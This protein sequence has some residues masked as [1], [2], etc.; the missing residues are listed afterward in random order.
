MKHF[1]SMR[2]VL[3]ILCSCVLSILCARVAL[4]QVEVTTVGGEIYTGRIVD[5]NTS[6]IML[7][8]LDS[9]TVTVPKSSVQLVRYGVDNSPARLKDDSFWS[10]G[11]A[12]GTPGLVNVIGGYNFDGWGLRVSGGLTPNTAAGLQFDLRRSVGYSG[13][14]SHNIHVSIGSFAMATDSPF[15]S[16]D[17]WDYVGIGYDLNWG[18]FYLSGDLS[19]GDGTY[20][21]PQILA[22]IGYVHE[23]R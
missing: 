21:S 3:H 4:A 13:S 5:E 23:F 6:L 9:V 16:Y 22:Q 1:N 11:G 14:L 19:F 18:G 17:W 8:T 12:L 15:R 10:L 2:I 7:M 20:S